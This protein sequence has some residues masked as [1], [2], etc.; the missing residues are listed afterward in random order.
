MWLMST[1]EGCDVQIGKREGDNQG[2][3]PPIPTSTILDSSLDCGGRC[4]DG[5]VDR[6][7]RHRFQSFLAGTGSA[8][9]EAVAVHDEE[10]LHQLRFLDDDLLLVTA[11]DDGA[12]LLLPRSGMPL[13]QTW[14]RC[15]VRACSARQGWLY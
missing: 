11:L 6:R 3:P 9:W 13:A 10:H 15:T 7:R 5:V 2:N 12:R 8:S 14:L 4:G 1:V